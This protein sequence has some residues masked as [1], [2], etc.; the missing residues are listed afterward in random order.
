M[1]SSRLRNS[2]TLVS[3]SPPARSRPPSLLQQGV[4]GEPDDMQRSGP[5]PEAEAGD[6]S[7]RSVG[8]WRSAP[9]AERPHPTMAAR[10][11]FRPTGGALPRVLSPGCLGPVGVSCRRGAEKYPGQW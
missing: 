9:V 4:T 11:A 3:D 5:S 2:A 6:R 7:C 10:R 8:N 1:T